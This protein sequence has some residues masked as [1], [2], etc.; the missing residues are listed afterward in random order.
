MKQKCMVG[1]RT[2]TSFYQ[3]NGMEL[4]DVE[5]GYDGC[6]YLSGYLPE[7]SKNHTNK[8]D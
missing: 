4:L 2:N 1:I 7:A 5:M 3:N 8:K 6:W